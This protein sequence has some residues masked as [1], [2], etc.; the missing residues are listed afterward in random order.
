MEEK[1]RKNAWHSSVRKRQDLDS[2]AEQFAKLNL[3]VRYL[4]VT[5]GIS[6]ISLI[7]TATQGS[8]LAVGTLPCGSPCVSDLW[9]VSWEQWRARLLLQVCPPS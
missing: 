1:G 2:R 8:C 7:I 6:V 5:L 4:S 3:S 9:G